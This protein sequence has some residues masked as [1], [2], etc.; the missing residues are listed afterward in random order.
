MNLIE[1]KR[2]L[3]ERGYRLVKE[4]SGP[5]GNFETKR[6]NPIEFTADGRTYYADGV[7]AGADITVDKS[8]SDGKYFIINPDDVDVATVNTWMD[9]NFRRVKRNET[10]AKA[11]GRRLAEPDLYDC[12]TFYNTGLD[13]FDMW[14]DN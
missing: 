12:W 7:L 13:M 10:L 5:Y 1:A 4:S 11:L 2:I 3:K 9:S 6:G 14:D 8:A